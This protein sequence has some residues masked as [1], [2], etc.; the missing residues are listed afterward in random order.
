[1]TALQD[2]LQFKYSHNPDP[3]SFSVLY[4]SVSNG[5][6]MMP[7]LVGLLV[8]AEMRPH[9]IRIDDLMVQPFGEVR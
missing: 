2:H 1:M 7:L 9:R 6:A 5:D 4:N 3:R 8:G